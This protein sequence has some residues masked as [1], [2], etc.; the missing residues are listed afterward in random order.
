MSKMFLDKPCYFYLGFQRGYDNRGD[1]RGGGRFDQGKCIV[2]G[3]PREVNREKHE[4]IVMEINDSK[5][6]PLL[7]GLAMS[8]L[9]VCIAKPIPFIDG[10]N[11]AKRHGLKL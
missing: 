3:D 11:F 5:F 4:T 9:F 1:D 7:N 2:P 6:F 10:I 8:L